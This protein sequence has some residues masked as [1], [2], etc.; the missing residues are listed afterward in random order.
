MPTKL[1]PPSWV[2]SRSM[3][4]LPSLPAPCRP[5]ASLSGNRASARLWLALA[6]IFAEAGPPGRPACGKDR[7]EEVGMIGRDALREYMRGSLWVLP[8]LSVLAALA[9]A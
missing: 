4:A 9:A 3:Q 7:I 8:T 2:L 5:A 1:S 6:R